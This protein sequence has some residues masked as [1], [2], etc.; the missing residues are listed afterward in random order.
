MEGI[1]LIRYAAISIQ[2]PHKDKGTWDWNFKAL[3]T[4]S[5]CWCFLST[6]AFCW[7]VTA[8]V[9][10]CIMPFVWKNYLKKN[11]VSLLLLMVLIFV[12]TKNL[13]LSQIHTNPLNCLNFDV[14]GWVLTILANCGIKTCVLDYYYY[15]FLKKILSK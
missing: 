13:H 9:N 4:L 8:Q 5:M 14:K 2:S 7:G 15:Y 11:L 3:A 1:L 6:V 12:S 10:R